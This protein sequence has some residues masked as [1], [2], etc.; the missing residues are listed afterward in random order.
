VCWL[1]VGLFI[2]IIIIISGRAVVAHAFNPSTWEAASLVYRG[3][4]RTA[5][6]TQRNPVFKKQQKNFF[7]LLAHMNY[8]HSN[9]FHYEIFI[10]SVMYFNHIHPHYPLVFVPL[11]FLP[12][13]PAFYLL[14]PVSGAGHCSLC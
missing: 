5:R 9:R 12:N 8:I 6:A 1:L 7:K 3:S 2:I 11:T 14:L 10:H 4:S 13:S